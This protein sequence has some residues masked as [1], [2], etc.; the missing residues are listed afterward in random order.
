MSIPIKIRDNSDNIKV[1]VRDNTSNVQVKGKTNT[2]QQTL[3][4][5]DNSKDIKIKVN[6]NVDEVLVNYGCNVKEKV[7]DNKITKEREERIAADEQE[8]EERIL[9]DNQER[10]ERIAAD[11]ELERQIQEIIVGGVMVDET[12]ITFN[13]NNE[14]SVTPELQETINN[15][16][17]KIEFVEIPVENMTGQI[18]SQELSVLTSNRINRLLRGNRIYYLSIREGDIRKYFSTIEEDYDEID[19]DITN[20]IYQVKNTRVIDHIND[21]TIHITQEDRDYWNNK[22]NYNEDTLDAG[23][24]TLNRQ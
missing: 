9:A 3:N 22:L 10:D 24:L 17:D 8:A 13:D 20:G 6:D 12:T 21:T 4:I 14:L 18:S 23:I 19:I 1:R 11:E 16:Q 2:E 15:K 7:L 5:K